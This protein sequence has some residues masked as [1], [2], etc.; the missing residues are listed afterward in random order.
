MLSLAGM[1]QAQE[2]P[3]PLDVQFSLFLKILTFDRSL[4]ARVGNEIVIGILYQRN[5]RASHNV[6]D[7]LAD[8]ID[9]SSVH[10]VQDILMR[11]VSI[12]L[13][14]ETDFATAVLRHSVDILY[15]APLRAVGIETIYTVSRARQILTLTGVPEYVDS[16]LAVSIGLRGGKPLIVINL[17]ASK[18][19]GADFHSQLLKLA[20]VI[21]HGS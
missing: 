20:K 5:F 21:R 11:H 3:V 13:S 18:A 9:K 10:Q 17:S 14:D 6:R 1:S 2:M 7:E 19:E 16:G 8:L 15:I 4:R 12:D